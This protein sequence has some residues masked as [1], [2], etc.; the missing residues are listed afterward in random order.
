MNTPIPDEE[1]TLVCQF[2]PEPEDH[3]TWPAPP[4]SPISSTPPPDLAASPALQAPALP[5]IVDELLQEDDSSE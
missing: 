5:T 1:K 4:L 3:P 2:P